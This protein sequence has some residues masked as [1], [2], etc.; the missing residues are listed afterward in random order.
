[1][2][3]R[4]EGTEVGAEEQPVA[5]Y[6]GAPGQLLEIKH[7]TK[8]YGGGLLEGVNRTVALR[9]FSLSIAEQPATITT[10]AGES[11]SGKTTLANAILGFLTLTSGQVVYRGL[12][13]GRDH[14]E[15]LRV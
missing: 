3:V 11:G 14:G 2:T 6:S 15:A 10:I 7:A 5:P 9:D 4:A 13:V 12:D 8:I 1:M